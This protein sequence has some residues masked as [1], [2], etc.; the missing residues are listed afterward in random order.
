M[1]ANDPPLTLPVRGVPGGWRDAWSDPD[2]H[3]EL[4]ARGERLE[5]Q[6]T[7]RARTLG[8]TWRQEI[9]EERRQ[10]ITVLGRRNGGDP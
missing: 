6:T 7:E 2:D 3:A 9:A 1:P 4:R 5:Q 8:Q 10:A